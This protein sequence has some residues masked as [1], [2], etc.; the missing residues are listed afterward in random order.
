MVLVVGRVDRTLSF[1]VDLFGLDG[2]N[3]NSSSELIKL[4]SHTPLVAILLCCRW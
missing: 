2:V 3:V 4:S 1:V